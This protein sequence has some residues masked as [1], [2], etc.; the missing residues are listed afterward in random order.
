MA[1]PWTTTP[2]YC[3][4]HAL[5]S[6]RMLRTR[7][8]LAP[9]LATTPPTPRAL[10]TVPPAPSAASLARRVVQRRDGMEDNDHPLA[11]RPA[12][13]S[14]GGLRARGCSCPSCPS[15]PYGSPRRPLLLPLIP[16]RSVMS[17]WRA[18][19]LLSLRILRR[20]MRVNSFRIWGVP[21]GMRL[22]ELC[23]APPN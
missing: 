19:S 12:A 20:P 11:A 9:A 5:F 4:Q 7:R 2:T 17:S 10:A 13:D 14:S 15:V 6:R 8:I 16:L 18:L 1:T 21:C 23:P 22:D 3:Y